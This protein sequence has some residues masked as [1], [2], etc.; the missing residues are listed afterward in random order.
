MKRTISLLAP[1]LVTLTAGTVTLADEGM[2]PPSQLP[3]LRDELK[4]LGL[5]IDPARLSDLTE[6]PMNAVISLGGCTASFVSPEALVITNHHCAYG[7]I[8]YNSTQERNLLEEG[9]LARNRS[10]E[11][12]ARPG[13]RVLVTVEVKDV[14][15][16]ILGGLKRGMSGRERYQAI[17]DR[18]KE[19]IAECEK[20]EGHR[21]NVYGFHGGL[22]YNLIKQLEI[23]D[24]R[25][26]YA[27]ASAIG[28]YGGDID[29][30][31]WPRH[32]GDFSFYRAYVGRDGKP[33]EHSEE[34]VPFRPKHYLKV[35]TDTGLLCLL[36]RDLLS[37]G[38]FLARLYD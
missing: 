25:L 32:V 29:N 10:E 38:W 33:A 2:W 20:D 28:N 34:N 6:H 23:L 1:I 18:E 22:Q 17:E 30:W 8:Q 15:D 5:R 14:T 12:P 24:V 27:P 9:F 4:S 26:V 19:L 35:A 31:M 21:C 37:G 7:S 3:E 16:R 13:T 11:L 36:Y